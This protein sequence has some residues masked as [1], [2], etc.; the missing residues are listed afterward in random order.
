MLPGSLADH[1]DAHQ[2]PLDEHRGTGLPQWA[3][4]SRP[5]QA[6]ARYSITLSARPSTERTSRPA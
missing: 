5:A 1:Y 6:S 4:S 2:R 3:T